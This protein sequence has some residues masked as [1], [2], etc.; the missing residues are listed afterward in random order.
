MILNKSL[1]SHSEFLNQFQSQTVISNKLSLFH[2]WWTY[3]HADVHTKPLSFFMQPF[4]AGSITT[5]L[6]LTPLFKILLSANCCYNQSNGT[7]RVFAT[8]PHFVMQL[9]DKSVF[10]FPTIQLYF[11][12]RV[13]RVK[14]KIFVGKWVKNNEK[15]SRYRW[16]CSSGRFPNLEI[17][18]K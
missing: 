12:Q 18:L 17:L 7:V 15:C 2:L 14:R 6:C 13:V 10:I 8:A 3:S 5:F 9:K 11:C 4:G 16:Y 1:K